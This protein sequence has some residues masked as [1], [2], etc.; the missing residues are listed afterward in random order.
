MKN[1]AHGLN[2]DVEMSIR[3]DREAPPVPGEEVRVGLIAKSPREI[4]KQRRLNYV[5]V[6]LAVT[7]VILLLIILIVYVAEATAVPQ[8]TVKPSATRAKVG[9]YAASAIQYFPKD[10]V[11]VSM[12]ENY[13]KHFAKFDGFIAQALNANPKVRIVTLPQ[14]SN[15]WFQAQAR[16]NSFVNNSAPPGVQYSQVGTFRNNLGEAYGEKLPR[17]EN[18][19]PEIIPCDDDSSGPKLKALSCLAKK[20]GVYLVGDMLELHSQECKPYEWDLGDPGQCFSARGGILYSV[21]VAFSPTG[22]FLAK[23]VQRSV[24]DPYIISQPTSTIVPGF[25]DAQI[26]G[27]TLRFGMMLTSDITKS[28]VVNDY[29]HLGITDIVLQAQFDNYSPAYL[30]GLIG[31]GFANLHG[32]NIIMSNGAT[33][34][35]VCQGGGIIPAGQ[36]D[37]ASFY[38]DTD[39]DAPDYKVVVGMLP[40]HSELPPRQLAFTGSVP[41]AIELS[42]NKQSCTISEFG[43]ML[44]D[45][46]KLP[47]SVAGQA[48]LSYSKNVRQIT[49]DGFGD[50]SCEVVYSAEIDEGENYALTAFSLPAKPAGCKNIIL[51][52]VCMVRL[53]NDFPD[54]TTSSDKSIKSLWSGFSIAMR[55]LKPLRT[56]IAPFVGVEESAP[57]YGQTPWKAEYNEDAGFARLDSVIGQW[58]SREFAAVG[59][60]SFMPIYSC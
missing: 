30:W 22:Q 10:N 7:G 17:I 40:I 32:I 16:L 23:H 60:N 56:S 49:Y 36:L 57:I 52:R 24:E 15:G 29:K 11:D 53:C 39:P 12:S 28:E 14:G 2:R 27:H 21:S 19:V 18:G 5:L 50:A 58:G 48:A 47:S 46:V 26:E 59:V 13:E 8:G 9:E 3:D 31:Q 37:A 38:W 55:G 25:F 34:H 20:F 1:P 45:C 54:C 6:A 43:G 4:Q 35:N 42:Q 44:V 33:V 41:K 51:A